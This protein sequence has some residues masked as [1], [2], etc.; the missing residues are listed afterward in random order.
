MSSSFIYHDDPGTAYL[1]DRNTASKLYKA[2]LDTP[3]FH[4][5]DIYITG[6]LS[7]KVNIR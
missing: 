2:S 5:E 3:I 7:S 4:L 6:I 1:M